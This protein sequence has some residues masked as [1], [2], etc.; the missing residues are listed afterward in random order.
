[1][2]PEGHTRGS[3]TARIDSDH[4]RRHDE[5][6]SFSFGRAAISFPIT[7]IT[8]DG[9]GRKRYDHPRRRLKFLGS[10]ARAAIKV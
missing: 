2:R 9:Q 1:M 3:Q 4:Q 7:T 8:S 10:E 6:N 5:S